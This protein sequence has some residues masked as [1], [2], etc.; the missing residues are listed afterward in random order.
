MES[1]KEQKNSFINST[2]A[3]LGAILLSVAA[4]YGVGNKLHNDAEVNRYTHDVAETLKESGLEGKVPNNI[5]DQYLS[6]QQKQSETKISG[7]DID[8]NY[9]LGIGS[10]TIPDTVNKRSK[11]YIPSKYDPDNLI[12]GMKTELAVLNPLVFDGAGTWYG[13]MIFDEGTPQMVWVNQTAIIEEGGEIDIED[14]QRF[15]AKV[16]T[17]SGIFGQTTSPNGKTSEQLG[18][19]SSVV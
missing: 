17:N 7:F 4:I 11:P 2:R 18:G 12:S 15:E 14:T 1:K 9:E 19:Y 3:K 16:A 10:I 13:F 5:A 6:S 8:K